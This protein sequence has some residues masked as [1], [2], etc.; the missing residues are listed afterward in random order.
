MSLNIIFSIH[1]KLSSYSSSSVLLYVTSFGLVIFPNTWSLPQN[2]RSSETFIMMTRT[3][4]WT[5]CTAKSNHQIEFKP[6]DL[7]LCLNTTSLSRNLR[8]LTMAYNTQN[9][10]WTLSIVRNSKYKKIQFGNWI[11]FRN[12]M[13]SYIQNSGRR[14]K[15]TPLR[16][17]VDRRLTTNEC[18]VKP[19]HKIKIA[20]LS[21]VWG[22]IPYLLDRRLVSSRAGFAPWQTKLSLSL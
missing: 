13:F 18:I 22:R 15:T 17:K 21:N 9:Y 20:R 6:V 12:V 11:Y 2:I 7:S 16:Y 5:R 14:A 8:I 3:F 4:I 19:W 10:F 1:C